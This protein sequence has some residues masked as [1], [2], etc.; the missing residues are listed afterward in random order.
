FHDDGTIW[1]RQNPPNFGYTYAIEDMAAVLGLSPDDFDESFPIQESST[2]LAFI[3]V[4]LKTLDAVKRATM[5]L[6]RFMEM[7]KQGQD[8]LAADALLMFCP[9]TERKEN[10]LHARVFVHLHG[11]PEDPATGSA[12]GCLAGYLAKHQYF[13]SPI[14][15]ARVEQGYEINRPSLLLLDAT[16]HDG[17]IEVNVGGRVQYVAK[18]QLVS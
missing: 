7:I 14:A 17:T 10:D 11:I 9:E 18:G 6:P 4:P 3:I 2:G 15:K 16:D 8:D 1:M 13:G 5:N 12:N